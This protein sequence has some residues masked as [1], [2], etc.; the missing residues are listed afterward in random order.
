[1][2]VHKALYPFYAT[3]KISHVSVTITKMRFIGRNSQVYYDN[4]HSWLFAHF[5]W[6][7]LLYK[8]AMP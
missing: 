4:L 6:R 1:M 2:D 8:Q 7:V 5:Q 3:K